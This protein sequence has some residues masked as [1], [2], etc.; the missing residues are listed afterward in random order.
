MS[1]ICSHNYIDLTYV[2]AAYSFPAIMARNEEKAQG[3][4]NRWTAMKEGMAK[5]DRG[6]VS[7][8]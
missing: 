5:R 3:M 6:S 2:F 7:L 8:L 4:M 1:G